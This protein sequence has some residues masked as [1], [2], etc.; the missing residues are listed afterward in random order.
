MGAN[1]V[2]SFFF[3]LCY[4]KWAPLEKRKEERRKRVVGF[5]GALREGNVLPAHSHLIPHVC[6]CSDAGAHTCI[7]TH[8]QDPGFLGHPLWQ[9]RFS[10][11]VTF[12]FHF[13]PLFTSSVAA[14][15]TK[16]LEAPFSKVSKREQSREER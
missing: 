5:R 14:P 4:R 11:E 6:T 9:A 3:S 15:I 1:R 12:L 10:M 7:H 8:R 16:L 13:Y 2:L